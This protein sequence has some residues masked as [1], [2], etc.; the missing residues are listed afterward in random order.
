MS[1][2]PVEELQTKK[3]RKVVHKFYDTEKAYVDGLDLIYSVSFYPTCPRPLY[4]N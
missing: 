1:T 3:R 2:K 4:L